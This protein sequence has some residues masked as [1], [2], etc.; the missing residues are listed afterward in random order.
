[1]AEISFDL[2]RRIQAKER[3]PFLAKI[4]EDFYESVDQLL[5]QCKDDPKRIREYDNLS[6]IIRQIT[7][8]RMEKI[9]LGALNSMRGLDKP[10]N[11]IKTEEEF[12]AKVLDL[13]KAFRTT[14]KELEKVE[15][16]KETEETKETKPKLRALRDIEAFVGLDGKTYGPF[17]E[18]EEIDVPE[19]E[20]K[21]LIA[22]G[23]AKQQQI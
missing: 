1:M 10:A 20:E 11:M 16:K 5:A 7:F 21:T 14:K 18:G 4:S 8:R 3:E 22:M 23:L 13:V 17:K 2:L 15:E 6:K 12:Y 19:E 9:V